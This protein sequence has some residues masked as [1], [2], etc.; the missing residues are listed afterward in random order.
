MQPY[1]NMIDQP[2]S[3]SVVR[4]VCEVLESHPVLTGNITNLFLSMFKE[5]GVPLTN[6]P[7]LLLNT[8][9]D[10]PFVCYETFSQIIPEL[11]H[12]DRDLTVQLLMESN[13]IKSA[14]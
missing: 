3:M 5:P 2:E 12:F 13:L 1:A 4:A 6:L 7:T 8:F 10:D 14:L 9:A 11:H